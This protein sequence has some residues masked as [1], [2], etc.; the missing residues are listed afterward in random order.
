MDG[1]EM[2]N[3]DNATPHAADEYDGEV[4]KTIPFYD[5]YHEQTIDLIKHAAPGPDI[6][7]DTG[8]GAGYLV[9]RAYRE[10]PGTRFILSDPSAKMLE[11]ARARLSGLDRER[12][13]FLEPAGSESLPGDLAGEPRV[14]T[15]LQA[16]HYLDRPGRVAAVQRCFDLLAEGGIFVV[17]ENVRPRTER[18]AAT[19][20]ARWGS[21]Q[22]SQGRP[23]DVVAAHAKRF[24]TR[25]FPITVDE[26]LDLLTSAG[27]NTVELFYFLYMQAGFFAV[28]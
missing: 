21:F 9:S 24:G 2:D 7:L 26:H 28:K 11:Q 5:F 10:F 3:N 23:A 17:F 25:Y 14:I 22:R 20:L 18:G 15:A 12:L 6:W 16:H 19:G 27:F 13:E 4:R 8:C 1:D